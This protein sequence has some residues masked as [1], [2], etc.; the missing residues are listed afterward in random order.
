[1]DKSALLADRVSDKTAEVEIEGVGTV[2]VRALS[3]WEMIQGGKL[4]DLAQERFILSKAMIDPPMGE[5]DVAEW[6]K[7]SPPGEINKVATVVNQLSGIGQ[8]ADKSS[9]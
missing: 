3:R 9:V 1:V 7:C 8:G 2:T 6:Q 5:H 4:E